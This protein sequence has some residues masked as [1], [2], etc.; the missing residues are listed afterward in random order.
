MAGVVFQCRH[1]RALETADHV[2]AVGGDVHLIC[3]S[4]G[5]GSALPLRSGRDPGDTGNPGDPVGPHLV[6]QADQGDYPRT[7]EL[8]PSSPPSVSLM[9]PASD[10]PAEPSSSTATTAAAAT[11]TTTTTT[12]P[13][14]AIAPSPAQALAGPFSD[15]QLSAIRERLEKLPEAVDLQV[16]LGERFV[17]LLTTRWPEATDHSQLVKA[18]A[19][20]GEL[21]FIGSRYRVV[22]DVVAEEPRARAA[23]QELLTLAMATMSG[24]ELSTSTPSS[25][26][27]RTAAI[28]VLLLIVIAGAIVVF[29]TILGG[30]MAPPVG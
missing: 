1:C 24:K 29:K 25:S 27:G 23:Q 20:A 6:P 7:L 13:S 4:C 14:T 19:A 28:A 26:A 11:T 15:T 9:P 8:V 21:A 12:A 5:A 18:A 2:V 16:G 22:L 17:T 3:K 10:N 30:G